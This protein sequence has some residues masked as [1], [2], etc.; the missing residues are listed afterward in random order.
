MVRNTRNTRNTKSTNDTHETRRGGRRT[1]TNCAEAVSGD[2][3]VSLRLYPAEGKNIAY[4][5]ITINEEFG[6]RVTVYE[7]ADGVP[8]ISYP[9]YKSKSGDYINAAY[10][11]N[12]ERREELT[13]M[14][15]DVVNE[16]Y[17]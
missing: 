12:N 13:D 17:S 5:T 11:F 2:G 3:V 14:L 7:N 8:F 4:G 15:N 1:E 9:S 6:I 10:C 16:L